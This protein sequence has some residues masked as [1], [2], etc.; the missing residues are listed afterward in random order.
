MAW[1]PRYQ[2][3]T[4]RG[5]KT[6][7]LC[8]DV[9]ERLLQSARRREIFRRRLKSA[10]VARGL[11]PRLQMKCPVGD[12]VL[13]STAVSGIY[14]SASSQVIVRVCCGR[15]MRLDLLATA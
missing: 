10:R 2:R 13:H 15:E 9:R 5:P 7:I 12:H 8:K 3:K 11:V 1:Y 14:Y 4:G 6:A